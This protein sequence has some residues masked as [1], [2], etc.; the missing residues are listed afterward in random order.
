MRW[1]RMYPT[2]EMANLEA[3][4]RLSGATRNMTPVIA[5]QM[6]PLAAFSS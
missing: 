5:G 4:I 1:Q 3:D 2:P 6:T